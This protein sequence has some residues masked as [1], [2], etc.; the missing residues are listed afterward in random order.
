MQ[1]FLASYFLISLIVSI[2]LMWLFFHLMFRIAN[3]LDE[4]A[5]LL[6]GKQPARKSFQS[7]PVQHR[8][9]PTPPAS[10]AAPKRE[11]DDLSGWKDLT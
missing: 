11:K 9:S 2:A 7:P 5:V 10:P 8:P 1:D 4:I 3:K 6:G